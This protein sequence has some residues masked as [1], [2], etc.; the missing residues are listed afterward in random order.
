MPFD[1]ITKSKD[2]EKTMHRTNV[3]L[4]RATF[5]LALAGVVESCGVPPPADPDKPKPITARNG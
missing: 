5:L 2:L 4:F 1:I 3:R